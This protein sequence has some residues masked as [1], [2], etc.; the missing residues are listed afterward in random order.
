MLAKN[1]YHRTIFNFILLILFLIFLIYFF[2]ENLGVNTRESILF[3]LLSFFVTLASL[4]FSRDKTVLSW[5]KYNIFAAP[6]LI[7]IVV[8]KDGFNSTFIYPGTG[9]AIVS[10]VFSSIYLL[11]SLAVIFY[12]YFKSRKKGDGQF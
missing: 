5:W 10:L 1:K 4:L 3:I 8:S 2:Y 6:I 11:G 7:L 12:S 9:R